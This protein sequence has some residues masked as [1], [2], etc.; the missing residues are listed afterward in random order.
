MAIQFKDYYEVLGVS[1]SASADEIRK[2]FR[3]LARLYHPDVA[4]NKAQAESKFNEINEAYEVLGDPEKRKRYDELGPNW[5]Q[6][7]E[8][9]PPS[10]WG[11]GGKARDFSGGKEGEFEFGGTGFSDFFEQV[12]GRRARGGFRPGS[13][14]GDSEDDAAERGQDV[15][16]DLLVT[17]HE[18]LRGSVRSITMQRRTPCDHC[19]GS[20]A[21]N[22]RA[23]PICHGDGHASK[24]ETC[25]VKIPAGVREGQRLRVPGRGHPGSGGAGSGD[26]YLRVRL[27]QHPDFDVEESDIF[28]ELNIAPWEAVLGAQ[29]PVP[30]LEG[31]VN[32]KIPPG[33][34]GW[35]RF[36]VRGQGLPRSGS[37]RGDLYAVLNIQVP[38]SISAGERKLWEQL[39]SESKFAPRD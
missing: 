23:C 8:F 28:C 14:F 33:A 11:Q 20:G 9:R 39:A 17:L 3:K 25:Q 38:V 34:Q 7:A 24:K 36:R 22:D 16:S 6:G 10:G 1:R 21:V 35:Q 13:T 27:E 2:S 32:I 12:F 26:L 31:T 30:T 15:E 18:A 19:F 5:K 29:V 37:E 4:K